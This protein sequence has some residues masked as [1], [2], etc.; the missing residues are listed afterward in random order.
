MLEFVLTPDQLFTLTWITQAI[1]QLLKIAAALIKRPIPDE[2][3]LGLVFVV[4]GLLGYFWAP[5]EWPPLSDPIAF[6]G[7]L[8]TNIGVVMAAAAVV[9]STLSGPILG[10]IDDKVVSR[11]PG[12]KKLDALLKP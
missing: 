12:L 11:I 6:I 4:S 3:K 7:T 5:V 2:Y 10:W 1:V 8:F 9:Y